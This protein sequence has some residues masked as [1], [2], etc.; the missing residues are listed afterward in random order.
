[1]G[2]F[3]NFFGQA[4]PETK[5]KIN[6]IPLTD[7]YQ[8]EEIKNKHKTATILIFKH[9]TRCGISRMVLKQFENLFEE[10]HQEFEAYYLDLLNFR[11]ISNAIEEQFKVRHQSPQLLVIKNGKL[12]EH[13][14]HYD[15]TQIDL[16]KYKL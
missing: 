5:L 3:D 16:N 6:W 2:L 14:T 15:I 7:I 9:S 1:M 11:G 10:N 12:I 4:T 8:L 13:A